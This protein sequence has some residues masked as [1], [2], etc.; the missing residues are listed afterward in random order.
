MGAIQ[1]QDYAMSKLA[2]G[3]R[4]HDTSHHKIEA[5]LDEGFILR[6][7]VL[8]PTWHL[9]H[10]EDIFWMLELTAPRIRAAMR[11]NNRKLGLDSALFTTCNDLLVRALEG[12]NHLTRAE[13]VDIWNR[14]NI[15]TDSSRVA[16]L[17]IQAELEGILCSGRRRGRKRTYALLQERVTKPAVIGRDEALLQLTKRY[18]SSHGPATAQDFSWWSGLTLTDV[19]KT[20]VMEKGFLDYH[21]FEGKTYWFNPENEGLQQKED[22]LLILA[23]FDELTIGY[24]DRSATIPNKNK[25]DVFPK[26]GFFRPIIV[27]N[28]KAIGTWRKF[29]RGD[30]IK[31][32][33]SFFKPTSSKVRDITITKFEDL[34][35]FFEK[36]IRI[37]FF[38]Y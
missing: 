37:E 10:K 13:I 30:E 29:I 26:N 17:L 36:D 9:V 4:L 7:H 5:A 28:W 14:A 15:A 31:M 16:H 35:K 32:E 25:H 19:R 20:L 38:N 12:C 8:R 1:A 11:S 24:T 23:A 21:N 3:S 2:I 18:F 22:V 27:Y 34:G 33:I 6:T